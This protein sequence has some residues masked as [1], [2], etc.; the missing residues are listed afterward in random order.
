M[1][2]AI[3]PLIQQLVG[4]YAAEIGCATDNL[5]IISKRYP[6][7]LYGDD[8]GLGMNIPELAANPNAGV[9]VAGIGRRF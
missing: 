3:H 9:I 5:P 6:D 8:P 7:G 2:N 4:E 1:V